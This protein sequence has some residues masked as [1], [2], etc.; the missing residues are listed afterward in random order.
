MA[1][2]VL[3]A[4]ELT[5]F[6]SFKGNTILPIHNLTV[7]AGRNSSGKS[8]ALDAI[9]ARIF[10]PSPRKTWGC[11]GRAAYDPTDFLRY[12]LVSEHL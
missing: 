3:R 10:G 7:L 1:T 9:V 2:A 5:K 12:P 8:N 11:R 4:I 6:K